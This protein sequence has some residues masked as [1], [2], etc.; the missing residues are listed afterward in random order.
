MRE[1]IKGCD[2]CRA[3]CDS[4]EHTL[5][6]CRATRGKAVPAEVQIQVRQA[7]RA[8]GAEASG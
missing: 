6:L 8:L 3:L 7:L 1:H 5:N 2:R 4:F